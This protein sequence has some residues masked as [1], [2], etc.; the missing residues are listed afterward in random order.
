MPDLP[1]FSH[2]SEDGRARMVDVGHK[3]PTERT[4]RAEAIAT[5][6]VNAEAGK[7]ALEE[8][9]TLATTMAQNKK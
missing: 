9:S 7:Q 6:T 1:E 2:V 8:V 5:A 4:A 3:A